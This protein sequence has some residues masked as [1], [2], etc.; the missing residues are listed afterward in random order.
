MGE[1]QGKRLAVGRTRRGLGFQALADCLPCACT[2]VLCHIC[3]SP[4]PGRFTISHCVPESGIQTGWVTCICSM[5]GPQLGV[6]KAGDCSHL[7]I[8]L[9]MSCRAAG[10]QLGCHVSLPAWLGLPQSVASFMGEHEV[11]RGSDGGREGVRKEREGVE[12]ERRG[13][14][15]V[16]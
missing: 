5:R 6:V 15:T 11:G 8:N 1:P 12:R 10:S 14:D 3:I 9:P 2:I 16:S 13:T 7:K 4:K